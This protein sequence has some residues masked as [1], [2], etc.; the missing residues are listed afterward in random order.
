MVTLPTV[1]KMSGNISTA[2]S[3]AKGPSGIPS[4][5]PIGAMELTKLTSP[6]RLT[7]LRLIR[8]ATNMAA[9]TRGK[10]G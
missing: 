1:R 4:V 10:S 2:I 5:M 7:A 9:M 8:T 3:N 6:G